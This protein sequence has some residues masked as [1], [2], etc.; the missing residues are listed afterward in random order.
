MAV[1]LIIDRSAS[2]E[3][4]VEDLRIMAMSISMACEK[5]CIPLS[6]WAL[7]GQVHIK[8]F[9]ESGPQV[10]AKLAGI[11]ADTY[12]VMMPT[13]ADAHKDLIAQ[14]DDLKQIV[15]IH[16]GFPADGDEFVEWRKRLRGVGLFCLRILSESDQDWYRD[17]PQDL[18]SQMDHLVGQQNYAIAPV[19]DIARHWCS[20]IRNK[21]FSRSHLL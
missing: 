17:A 2:M 5:L 19:T 3:S 21:R 18:R 10:L 6:I 16:D 1:T 11:E 8:A 13:I 14:P 7:E 20:F 15:L 12:T 9:Q 4:M